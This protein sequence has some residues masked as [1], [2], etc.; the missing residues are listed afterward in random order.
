MAS[1]KTTESISACTEELVFI[2]QYLHKPTLSSDG[3]GHDIDHFF[4]LTPV[5]AIVDQN[6]LVSPSAR[7]LQG[8]GQS[9]DWRWIAYSILGG[10]NEK[11]PGVGKEKSV[12][13]R[14]KKASEGGRERMSKQNDNKVLFHQGPSLAPKEHIGRDAGQSN[15]KYKV[16]SRKRKPSE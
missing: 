15:M 7:R 2:W 12:Y 11:I 4:D 8:I 13:D 10:G 3:A 14:E 6:D 16:R 5:E 1:R 9:L